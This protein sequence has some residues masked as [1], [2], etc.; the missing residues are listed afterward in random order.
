[1]QGKCFFAIKFRKGKYGAENRHIYL[2]ALS[3]S[4]HKY[5]KLVKKDTTR[6]QGA[7]RNIQ[8]GTQLV[9][10][11]YGEIN[12]YHYYGYITIKIGKGVCV[13]SRNFIHSQQMRNSDFIVELLQMNAL[14]Y[15]NEL[16]TN[17]KGVEMEPLK[18]IFSQVFYPIS[19]L[20]MK[21][22]INRGYIMRGKRE[23]G[24]QVILEGWIYMIS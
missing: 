23:E 7:N 19:Q 18:K 22:G 6:R 13:L 8:V 16:N 4:L 3:D 15:H 5:F 1:M 14:P 24:S 2:V 21:H 17:H 10:L 20:I 9:H 11:H 12:N